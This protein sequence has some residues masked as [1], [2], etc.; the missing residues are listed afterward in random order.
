MTQ[1]QDG[2][3]ER[4]RWIDSEDPAPVQPTTVQDD[5]DAYH[6][7]LGNLPADDWAGTVQD[8][9]GE[10]HRGHE[11]QGNVSLCSC[12]DGNHYAEHLQAVVTSPY[13]GVIERIV[14]DHNETAT[15][16]RQV[17]AASGL[18]ETVRQ[19]INGDCSTTAVEVAM[20]AY[21]AEVN[22]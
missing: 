18:R 1:E 16:T 15:L 2:K 19:Y 4:W 6:P 14:R 12:K 21:D 8:E 7:G 13:D 11:Y 17:R 9:T 5:F 3:G 22:R 10:W 20:A